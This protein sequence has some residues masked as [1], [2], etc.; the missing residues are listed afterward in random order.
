MKELNVLLDLLKLFR[1][2]FNP[3][4][5]T[6]YPLLTL[7]GSTLNLPL[8]NSKTL[9]IVNRIKF[10]QRPTVPV[11]NIETELNV[12]GRINKTVSVFDCRR[13]IDRPRTVPFSVPPSGPHQFRQCF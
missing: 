11:N 6:T 9:M 5:P 7:C 12:G 2:D 4:I 1:I 13:N 3:C 8:R 10:E